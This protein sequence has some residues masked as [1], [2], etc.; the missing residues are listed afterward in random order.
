MNITFFSKFW[1]F[2][3]DNINLKQTILKNTFWLVMAE[4]IIRILK[5]VL[6]IYVARIL[7][8]TEY[9]K[10]TFA[11]SFAMLFVALSD[12]GLSPITVREFS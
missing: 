12:L 1:S 4:I 7:G 6:V 9:G 8:A 2:F 11:L 3:L 10:F 5:L